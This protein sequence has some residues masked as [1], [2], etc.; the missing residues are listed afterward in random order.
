MKSDDRH[1]LPG[2]LVVTAVHDTSDAVDMW[3]RCY[4]EDGENLRPDKVWS[5]ELGLVIA[6]ITSMRSNLA[7]ECF[8]IIFPSSHHAGSIRCGWIL[9]RQLR[10]I[11]VG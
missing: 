3:S 11:D 2:D 10:S 1:I 6:S 7:D 4:D 9:K 5:D 8:V